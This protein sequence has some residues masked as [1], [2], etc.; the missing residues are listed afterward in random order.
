M[1]YALCPIPYA[2]CPMPVGYLI[3][4]RKAISPVTILG[5]IPHYLISLTISLK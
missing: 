4:L 1:P 3:F 5:F 2:L